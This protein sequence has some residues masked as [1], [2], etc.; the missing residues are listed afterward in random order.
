MRS[1]YCKPYGCRCRRECSILLPRAQRHEPAGPR[2]HDCQGLMCAAD[3]RPFSPTPSPAQHPNSCISILAAI[4][5][6]R[7]ATLYLRF[8]CSLVLC[9]CRGACCRRMLQCTLQAPSRTR[10][11]SKHTCNDTT[12]VEVYAVGAIE[13][14][15]SQVLLSYCLRT[16]LLSSCGCLL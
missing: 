1:S 11:Y 8:S 3:E 16:V 13:L 6:T 12:A 14:Y 2:E 5:Q 15:G 10:C 4:E 9:L 7:I